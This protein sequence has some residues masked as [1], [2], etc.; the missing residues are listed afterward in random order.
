MS[1]LQR[2]ELAFIHPSEVSALAQ[3]H[4]YYQYF[5]P[6]QHES[7]GMLKARGWLVYLSYYSL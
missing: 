1:L 3:K 5:S 2:S 6:K 4:S 7:A